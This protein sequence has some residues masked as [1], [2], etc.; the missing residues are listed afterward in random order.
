MTRLQP[1]HTNQVMFNKSELK[2]LGRV[3]VETLNPKNERC[4]L[5]EYTV[6]PSGHTALLGAETVQRVWSYRYKC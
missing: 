2:P 5:V 1:S 4:L 3:K 6:V